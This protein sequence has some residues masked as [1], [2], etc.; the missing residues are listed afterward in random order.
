MVSE[1]GKTRKKRIIFVCTGNSCRSPMAEGIA[2]KIFAEYGLDYEVDSFGTLD[3]D[4]APP[5]EFAVEVCR[6][7]GI[8]ISGHRSQQL[9][10]QAAEDADLILVMENYHREWIERNLG[11]D[12][13]DKVFLLTEYGGGAP[14]E[15]DD[16]IGSPLTAYEETFERIKREIERI[17]QHERGDR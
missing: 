11:A 17:A 9:T 15:I 7:H 3:L 5:S 8:D 12:L 16:P 1:S 14:A 10:R 4:G 6:R 13:M 2:R